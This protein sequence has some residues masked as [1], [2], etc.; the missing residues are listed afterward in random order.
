M[1]SQVGY[2]H[3]DAFIGQL[4]CLHLS[5]RDLDWLQQVWGPEGC[6][7]V[8]SHGYHFG[9]RFNITVVYP[10]LLPPLLHTSPTPHL[11]LP[12][13]SFP[14]PHWNAHTTSSSH[15]SL[16]AVTDLS[17][18]VI[19]GGTMEGFYLRDQCVLPWG[20]HPLVMAPPLSG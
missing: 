6:S 19:F 15:G 7:E 17:C 1:L 11:P 12:H 18:V 20:T 4:M 3:S 5:G 16:T 10:L 13:T 14:C 9:R 8:H 2:G